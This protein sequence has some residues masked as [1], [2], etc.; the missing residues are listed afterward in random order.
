MSHFF[1][2]DDAGRE[3]STGDLYLFSD[4]KVR[5]NSPG[6]AQL[7]LRPSLIFQSRTEPQISA[8][9]GEGTAK[10]R[11]KHEL[12]VKGFR[13]SIIAADVESSSV[14]LEAAGP[15]QIQPCA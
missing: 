8:N 5:M 3:N 12:L 4:V 10:L 15:S 9:Q 13:V 7:I 1:K 2:V 14:L 6:I 11:T